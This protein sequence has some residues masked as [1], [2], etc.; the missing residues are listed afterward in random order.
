MKNFAMLIPALCLAVSCGDSAD[1]VT[2]PPDTG[3][4]VV[5]ASGS[6]TA[7]VISNL[8]YAVDPASFE[9]GFVEMRITANAD[10]SG[11]YQTVFARTSPNRVNIIANPEIARNPDLE[12]GSYPCVALR[13]SDLLRYEPSTTE[14]VC[15]AGTVVERDIFRADDEPD[16][17]R[18]PAGGVLTARGSA[19]APVEDLVWTYITRDTAA[20]T[21]RGYATTQVIPLS[22]SLVVPG[23]TTFYWD[24][25]A[26][27][28][29]EGGMCGTVGGSIGFR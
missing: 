4:L 5:R 23:S 28:G 7:P 27:L 16:A 2:T 17:W 1:P 15:I 3:E 12:R 13:I 9:V 11:P 10:C 21:A 14:G 24:L 29:D 22:A 6:A 18:D 26:S 25:R 8:V 19:A 20:T